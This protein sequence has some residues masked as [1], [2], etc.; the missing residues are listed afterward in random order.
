[1]ALPQTALASE[2][3]IVL[4]PNELSGAQ[5][6]ELGAVDRALIEVPIEVFERCRRGEVGVLY[7]P[8]D[9]P[10]APGVRGYRQEPL[11]QAQNRQ[12]FLLRRGNDF[13]QLLGAERGFQ[14]FQVLEDSPTLRGRITLGCRRSRRCFA[15]SCLLR[16]CLG[17][18]PARR[19]HGCLPR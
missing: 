16:R 7:P 1:M 14:C 15:R 2:D 4:A 10:F 8:R 11:Q 5:L 12:L 19:R 18:R 13:I 9:T 6:L 17:V 3:D